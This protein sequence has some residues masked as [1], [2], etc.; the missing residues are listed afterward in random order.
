M[1][2]RFL[3][4]N[5]ENS[6]FYARRNYLSQS[7]ESAYDFYNFCTKQYLGLGAL[8]QFIPGTN[9]H[10][11]RTQLLDELSPSI[12][13]LQ[14]SLGI[15]PAFIS[16]RLG[17][18]GEFYWFKKHAFLQ[19]LYSYLNVGFIFK[20]LDDI[21]DGFE[22]SGIE[23]NKKSPLI[24]IAFKFPILKNIFYV[25]SER[26]IVLDDDALK[27]VLHSIINP[28]RII[29]DA[30]SFL[31]LGVY[32]LLD[33]G[34]ERHS[35]SSTP[36]GLLKAAIGLVFWLI[37]LPVKVLKHAIDFSL[38]MVQ[39][40]LIA[41]V[42]HV[43]NSIQ[44]AYQNKDKQVLIVTTKQL[45]D[46]KEL[47]RTAKGRADTSYSKMT[48]S[49]GY[50]KEYIGITKEELYRENSEERV[51]AIRAASTKIASLS[52][53]LAIVNIFSANHKIAK[54]EPEAIESAKKVLFSN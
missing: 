36:L 53:L 48:Q 52:S 26:K 7:L 39:T 9:A 14:E 44:V 23:T 37:K 46:L 2:Q 24:R 5:A 13:S 51:V 33:I 20:L 19:P 50:T 6:H 42:M 29:D 1:Y 32:R 28:L 18:G 40:L 25:D 38:N 16:Y 30:L 22:R 43:I 12:Q 35:N 17:G 27:N 21:A 47:R 4:A 10:L 15:Q 3:A 54:N 34:S 49:I 45:Q 31:H 8:L 41:P 11:T